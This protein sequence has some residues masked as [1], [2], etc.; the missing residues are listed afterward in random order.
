MCLASIKEMPKL[1]NKYFAKQ[2]SQQL[3]LLRRRQKAV[4]RILFFLNERIIIVHEGFFDVGAHGR[5][6]RH[7][8]VE[9]FVGIFEL[10]HPPVESVELL[11]HKQIEVHGSV[12][13]LS[14]REHHH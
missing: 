11:L 2:L 10:F 14:N 3:G 4:K 8:E 5:A 9:G 1:V 7:V 6:Q 12:K 13:C